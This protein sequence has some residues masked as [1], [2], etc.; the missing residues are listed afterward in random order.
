MLPIPILIVTFRNADE[1][2]EC[3][4]SLGKSNSDPAFDV[5][6]CENGGDVAFATLCARL[7]VPGGPC[8]RARTPAPCRTDGFTS[9][10]SFRLRGMNARIFAGNAGDNLGYGGGVNRWLRPLREAGDW[11]G[12]LILNPDTTVEP[13]ALGALVGY[14]RTHHK[15]MVTGRIAW[16]DNPDRIHIRGL[17]WRRVLANTAGVG[18]NEP[19]SSRPTA[20]SIERELDAPAGTLVY[21]TRACLEKI[22]LMEER[23]FLYYEDLDWGLRAKRTNDIGYAVD[24]LVFHKGGTTIGTGSVLTSSVF[25]TYLSSRNTVLFVYAHYPTWIAWTAFMLFARALEYGAHGRP[26]NM[27]AAIRGALDGLLRRDGRPDDALF[28]HLAACRT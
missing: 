3:L 13:A 23:Y 20:D 22:G 14:A 8:V 4:D 21:I 16:A 27:G 9:V 12:A 25:A 10:E 18:M 28:R 1:V 17:R 7:S 26:A 5:Y 19:V 24:A 11:P 2:V 15:G 6:V